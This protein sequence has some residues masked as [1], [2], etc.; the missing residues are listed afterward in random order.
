MAHLID[1]HFQGHRGTI[2]AFLVETAAGPVLV[3]SGPAT[4]LPALEKGLGTL[5]FSLED[6]RHVLLTHIHFDH[7]GAAWRLAEAGATIHVHPFGV[8]HLVDSGVLW[9]SAKRIFGDS[10]DRL[11][12]EMRPIPADQVHACED[13]AT[14]EMGDR[15]FTALHTPGHAKH[16]IA[17]Q[18]GGDE[19]V[20]FTGDVAGVVLNGGPV[21][22]PCPPPDIDLEAW[23]QSIARLRAC[24]PKTLYLTH[25]GAVTEVEPLLAALEKSLED[26]C[27]WMEKRVGDKSA[28]ELIPLFETYVRDGLREAGLGEA[29][30]A[31]YELAN[32]AF[33]SVN[34]LARYLSKKKKKANT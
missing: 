10:M 27:Q 22:P 21:Q 20:I 31:D 28:S 1:L 23:R 12:G 4:T 17:W 34:G 25:F 32:P 29:A 8:D 26:W 30:M 15:V 19:R 11:W 33:M 9:K 2:A 7:A 14:L 24:E 16:H 13:G 6:V 18:L 5:G 3:E